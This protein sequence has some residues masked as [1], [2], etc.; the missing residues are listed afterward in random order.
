MPTI[1]QRKGVTL[2]ISYHSN[3]T[4]K[5]LSS[6]LHFLQHNDLS[7]VIRTLYYMKS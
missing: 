3:R 2:I 7:P 5:S 6:L 4:K 1:N